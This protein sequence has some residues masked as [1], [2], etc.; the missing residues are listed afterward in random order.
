M[1][2]Y[3][4]VLG[5]T[6][7]AHL[8]VI[9][10]AYKALAKVYHPDR[11]N[12]DN[13]FAKEKMQE[14]NEAYNILS[15]EQLRSSYD[16]KFDDENRFYST[17]FDDSNVGDTTDSM[18]ES[19]WNYAVEFYPYIRFHYEDLRRLSVK[20]AQMYKF[21]LLDSKD[22]DRAD[23][24]KEDLESNFIRKY[25]GSSHVLQQRGKYHLLN[26]EK[27]IA[28]EINKAAAFFGSNVPVEQILSKI[29]AKYGGVD[30]NKNTT[31]STSN[32][33]FQL[34]LKQGAIVAAFLI[35]CVSITILNL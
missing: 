14:I 7:E 20:L 4:D 11:W 29:D 3:Y 1:P 23:R 9:K 34:S 21:T 17:D 8:V 18:F 30:F 16:Q 25:F 22:F 6:P 26:K 15:N 12:G 28:L 10:A 24:L 27:H 19:D 32:N 33:Y 2:T 35:I 31:V 13:K 5:V